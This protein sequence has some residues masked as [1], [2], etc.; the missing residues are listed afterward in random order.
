MSQ[1]R[2]LY[3]FVCNSPT[4]DKLV[5][6]DSS[7][8]PV[9]APEISHDPVPALGAIFSPSTDTGRNLP[10]VCT[11]WNNRIKCEHW[12][13]WYLRCW[14]WAPAAVTGHPFIVPVL[15]PVGTSHKLFISSAAGRNLPRV[16]TGTFFG[17]SVSTGTVLWQGLTYTKQCDNNN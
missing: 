11:G 13:V 10:C 7:G 4:G 16:C 6:S 12:V 2:L 1:N 15:E 17:P 3:T 8:R 9:P 14:H 5:P